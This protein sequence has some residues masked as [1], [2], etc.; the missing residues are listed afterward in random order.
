MAS[1]RRRGSEPDH[2]HS[3]KYRDGVHVEPLNLDIL[4]VAVFV[5]ETL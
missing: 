5:N 1:L 4:N 3:K 2:S